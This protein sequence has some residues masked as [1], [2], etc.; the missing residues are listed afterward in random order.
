VKPFSVRLSVTLFQIDPLNE[1]TNNVFCVL[2]P[3]RPIPLLVLVQTK[4]EEIVVQ[5][6]PELMVK[7]GFAGTSP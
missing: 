1:S 5:N 2:A 3:P 6:F 7:H 4:Q